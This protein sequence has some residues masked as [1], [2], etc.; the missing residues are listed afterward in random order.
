MFRLYYDVVGMREQCVFPT[1]IS[2]V[3]VVF[4]CENLF[5]FMCVCVCDW[6][7]LLFCKM[8]FIKLEVAFFSYAYYTLKWYEAF[9]SNMICT[10]HQ[11]GKRSTFLCELFNCYSCNRLHFRILRRIWIWLNRN[12]SFYFWHPTVR[13]LRLHLYDTFFFFELTL[14]YVKCVQNLSIT[15]RCSNKWLCLISPTE[16]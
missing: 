13:N 8:M 11:N 12:N 16:I 3:F 14:W 6:F 10:T 4:V 7:L 9:S 1:C 15:D 2:I 5:I